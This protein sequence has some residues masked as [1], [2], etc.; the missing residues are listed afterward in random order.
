MSFKKAS[1]VGSIL[2]LGVAVL[3]TGA[4]AQAQ[5]NEVRSKVLTKT[6]LT[7]LFMDE[8]CDG[9][10][11]LL[12]DYDNDGIPN[13]QDPDWTRPKDGTGY[14]SGNG[15][16]GQGGAAAGLGNKGFLGQPGTPFGGGVCDGTGPKGNAGRKGR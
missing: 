5:K 14:K 9:L 6:E 13:G 10:N 2:I 1:K 4:F 11:D 15:R 3:F 12:R 16:G 7:V 8:N